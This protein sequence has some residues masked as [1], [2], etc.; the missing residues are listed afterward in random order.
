MPAHALFV[1]TV[2]NTGERIMDEGHLA[3]TCPL[4]GRSGDHR[5]ENLKEG[6]DMVCPFCSV[7]LNLHG[8]MWEEIQSQIAKLKENASG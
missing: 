3:V 8:H 4:C 5:I 6:A 7:K 1:Y 2:L